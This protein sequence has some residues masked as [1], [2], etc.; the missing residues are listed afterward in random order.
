MNHNTEAPGTPAPDFKQA[1]D[2]GNYSVESAIVIANTALILLSY[3]SGARSRP[4]TAYRNWILK[5][6]QLCFSGR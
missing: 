5:V 6:G 4:H 1:K 3:S 2:E